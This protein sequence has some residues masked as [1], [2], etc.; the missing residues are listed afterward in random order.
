M[1]ASIFL[2][3]LSFVLLFN[4][5]AYRM[6]KHAL[7]TAVS[8]QAILANLFVLK[9]VPF[10][11]FHI[12]CSDAFA[13]GNIM[14]LNLIREHYGKDDAKTAIRTCFFFMAFFVVMSQIHLQFMPSYFD[15]TH[16]AYARLFSP[17]PRLLIASLVTFWIVQQ[18]DLRAFGWVSNLLPRSPFPIRSSISSTASQL[19]D[20]LVFSVFGL[21]GI[22]SHL[23]HTIVVSFV[24]KVGVI[25]ILG[26]LMGALNR[27]NS[28]A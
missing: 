2:Y 8:V 21:M 7:I 27:W 26:P 3:Q 28:R 12:T 1:N 23:G 13:V 17:S 11:G 25:L 19:L 14:S 6:G 20:T 10:F 5:G 15:T 4:Y 24:V 9:Q 16:A 22:V 18:F